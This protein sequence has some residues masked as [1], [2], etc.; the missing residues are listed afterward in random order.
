M[1]E[2]W[3]FWGTGVGVGAYIYH[4]LR[5]DIMEGYIYAIIYLG[6]CDFGD[7]RAVYLS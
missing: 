5:T 3:R 2:R 6:F 1:G 4:K 7:S